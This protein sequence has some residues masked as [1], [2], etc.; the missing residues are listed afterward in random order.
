MV[1]TMTP[2]QRRILLQ[3]PVLAK[4]IGTIGLP[5]AITVVVCVELWDGLRSGWRM[6]MI[7]VGGIWRE[8]KDVWRF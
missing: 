5:I 7:E 1:I 3:H 8:F 2:E 6:A 4:T